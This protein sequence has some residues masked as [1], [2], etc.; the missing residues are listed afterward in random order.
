MNHLALSSR[1]NELSRE[2]AEISD[3]YDGLTVSILHQG[4]IDINQGKF[5]SAG[6]MLKLFSKRQTPPAFLY[7]PGEAEHASARLKFYQGILTNAHLNNVEQ[8]IGSG[9][10]LE[11]IKKLAYLR[12]EWEL[13]RGNTRAALDAVEHTLSIAR[14]TGTP[15]SAYLGIRA[16]TLVR[17]SHTAEGQ[18]SLEEAAAIWTNHEVEFPLFAA[19]SWLAL[20]DLKQACNWIQKAYS[21]AWADGP[22]HIHWYRLKRCREL[23][24]GL[25]MPEPQL[26]PFDPNKIETDPLETEIRYAIERLKTK[27]GRRA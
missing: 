17:L 12:A 19:E 11:L 10:Y 13:T 7:R 27:E 15:A 18:E 24:T 21:L 25:G 22:P 5:K 16:L 20:G 8:I 3:D 26:L 4:N 1:L 6:H 23:M 2:V 14:I 9:R